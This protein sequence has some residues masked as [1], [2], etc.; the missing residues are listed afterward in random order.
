MAHKRQRGDSE[1]RL[2]LGRQ[3]EEARFPAAPA[4][5]GLPR[6][7]ADALGAIKRRIQ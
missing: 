2:A 4:R 7:Y 6:D 3:R 1:N 5:A